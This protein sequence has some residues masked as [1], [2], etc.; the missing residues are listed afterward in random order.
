MSENVNFLSIRDGKTYKRAINNGV[1]KI[2]SRVK[3][4]QNCTLFCRES[5][6]CRDFMLF[7]GTFWHILKLNVTFWHFYA[8]LL[9][10]W[11]FYT[12]SRKKLSFYMSALNKKS[13]LHWYRYTSTLVRVLILVRV[14]VLV[15]VLVLVQISYCTD[16]TRWGGGRKGSVPGLK[17]PLSPG[18]GGSEDW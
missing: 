17:P 11:A 12:V 8:L 15:L 1:K 13:L 14:R 9:V 5:E 2:L 7:G 4:L 16:A 10:F 6:S 3:S 18:K